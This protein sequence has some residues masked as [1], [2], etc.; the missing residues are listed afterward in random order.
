[1]KINNGLVQDFFN[2]KCEMWILTMEVQIL[3]LK[4]ST[5]ITNWLENVLKAITPEYAIAFINLSFTTLAL[6]IFI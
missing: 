3:F 5:N 2:S 1:M 6:K 4:F